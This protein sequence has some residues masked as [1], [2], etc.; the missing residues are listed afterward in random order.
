MSLTPTVTT[1]ST[2]SSTTTTT[3]PISTWDDLRYE[4]VYQQI[5]KLSHKLESTSHGQTV[6]QLI[7]DCFAKRKEPEMMDEEVGITIYFLRT[8]FTQIT[9]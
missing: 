9:D 2:L 5:R 7:R 6:R 8:W 1:S 4:N 3:D